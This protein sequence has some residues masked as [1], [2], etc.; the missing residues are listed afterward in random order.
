MGKYK[1][2]R[3]TLLVKYRTLNVQ[4]MKLKKKKSTGWMERTEKKAFLKLKRKWPSG[5][6]F[7]RS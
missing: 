1:H 6:G 3:N 4:N 5:K 7:R 2:Q